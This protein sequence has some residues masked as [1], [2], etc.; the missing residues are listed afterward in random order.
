MPNKNE[1]NHIV[2]LSYRTVLQ[3]HIH[4]SVDWITQKY[5]FCPN[6]G[7]KIDWKQIEEMVKDNG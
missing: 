3:S 4:D 7:A 2:G 6:C 1:C 5:I